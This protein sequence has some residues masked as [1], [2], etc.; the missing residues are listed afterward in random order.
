MRKKCTLRFLLLFL[1][2]FVFQ[3]AAYADEAGNAKN[4]R[5]LVEVN[6]STNIVSVYQNDADGNFTV[7]IKAFYCSTGSYTP[8]GSYRTSDKY[9][10]RGLFGNVYGQYATRITGHILFHSV[11]YYKTSKDTLEYEEYNKLGT[12]ASSGCI[13][14]TVA[15]AKWIYDNCPSGTEVQIISSDKPSS[16]TPAEPIKLDFSDPVKRNWD[17]TDPD[18]ANPWLAELDEQENQVS[19][20]QANFLIDG[21]VFSLPSYQLQNSHYLRLSD[22][23]L[24]FRA[25]DRQFAVTVGE[26]GEMLLTE[27]DGI[28]TD[29]P[30]GL[31]SAAPKLKQTTIVY[32]GVGKP[33]EVYETAS[34]DIYKLRDIAEILGVTVKWDPIAEQISILSDELTGDKI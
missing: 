30:A 26:N 10:W 24:L 5:Y 27:S 1:F 17:P 25:L 16:I 23:S 34:G 11:P 13:R 29:T 22:L 18:E 3:T 4:R 9:I 28:Q 15:D 6:K 20:S 8:L 2:L 12:T 32:H 7:P 19:P 33:L 21:K 14:L 31:E